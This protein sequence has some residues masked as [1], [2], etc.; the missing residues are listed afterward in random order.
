ML[1][2][3][4]RAATFFGALYAAASTP[5][6]LPGLPAYEAALWLNLDINLNLVGIVAWGLVAP[7]IRS[8]RVVLPNWLALIGM[9]GGASSLIL[10][11]PIVAFLVL[12]IAFGIWCF[13]VPLLIRRISGSAKAT[14]PSQGQH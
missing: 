4:L 14:G 12:P 1:C 2:L 9:I 10:I 5:A 3:A 11:V 13:A 6:P 8:G 7:P